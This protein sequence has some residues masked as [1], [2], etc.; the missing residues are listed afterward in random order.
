MIN[1]DIFKC[2]LLLGN[3]EK[4]L[5]QFSSNTFHTVVTS[6]PYWQLRDYKVAA[7]L[8][9]E[10]TPQEYVEKIVSLGREI[11]RVLRDDG[12]FWLNLGDT[13]CKKNIKKSNLK[14]QDLV[15]IPWRVALALQEDGWYLRSDIIWEKENPQPESQK[16]RPAKSHEHLFLFSKTLKY[17][18][19]ADA[20]AVPQKE[21]S[22]KRAFSKNRVEK[23][24]DYGDDNYAIS[25]ESQ[26]K[27]YEKMRKKI[28]SGA[29]IMRSIRDVWRIA[30][31][32]NKLKHFAIM[33]EKLVE[34]C[35][36]AGSSSKGCCP[37]CKVPWNRIDDSDEWEAG[38][39]CGE[40]E[41]QECLVLD[42]FNG[43][44][45]T[46]RVCKSF[47]RKYVGIDINEKYLNIARESLVGDSSDYFAEE[48]SSIEEIVE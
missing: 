28:L 15:G 30:T 31:A 23:R 24:K 12:T 11:K 2:K 29:K 25:G 17:Y 38:C 18:Y 43:S 34:R 20:I 35:I 36:L 45:T 42:P 3:A 41:V 5:E 48:V 46:G 1:S 37:K 8:G 32:N 21:I 9:Q 14:Q 26:N 27:T 33:P 22:I 39:E 40:K 7:Q 44:G 4:V 13:Y 16:R 6:P 19:D 47:H 10:E